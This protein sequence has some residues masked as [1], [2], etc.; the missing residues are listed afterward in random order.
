[1][2]VLD[3][4]RTLYGGAVP[5]DTVASTDAVL[6]GA[7]SVC[8]ACHGCAVRSRVLV[9]YHPVALRVGRRKPDRDVRQMLSYPCP[10]HKHQPAHNSVTCHF[11][12]RFSR[13]SDSFPGF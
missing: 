11:L 4:L 9:V 5:N 6:S 3:R 10:G 2:K 8:S 7:I 1:M 13:V 12:K